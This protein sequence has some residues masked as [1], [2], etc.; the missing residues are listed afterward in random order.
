M[1]SAR[2]AAKKKLFLFY[3]FA[4]T[5]SWIHIAIALTISDSRKKKTIVSD[6]YCTLTPYLYMHLAPY[7]SPQTSLLNIL[8]F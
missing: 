8:L 7:L 3:I 1:V 2:E 6:Y 4:C 5:A